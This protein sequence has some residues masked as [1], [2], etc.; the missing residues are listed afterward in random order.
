MCKQTKVFEAITCLKVGIHVNIIQST[1]RPMNIKISTYKD[2][3][4]RNG[5]VNQDPDMV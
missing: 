3:R 4:R 5:G 2:G 1:C